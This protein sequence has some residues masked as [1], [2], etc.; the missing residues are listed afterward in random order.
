MAMTWITQDLGM[1]QRTMMGLWLAVTQHYMPSVSDY[2]TWKNGLMM[3]ADTREVLTPTCIKIIQRGGD[4]VSCLWKHCAQ[5]HGISINIL[6]RAT[7]CP[8]C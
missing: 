4:K 3:R 8:P 1:K 2:F 6:N 7:A 5:L